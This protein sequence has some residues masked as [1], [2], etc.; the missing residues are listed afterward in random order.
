MG[1]VIL[2]QTFVQFKCYFL[3]VLMLAAQVIFPSTVVFADNVQAKNRPEGIPAG[4]GASVPWVEYEA[5]DGETNATIVGPSTK[6]GDLAGEASGRKAVKLSSTGDHVQ[7]ITTAPANSIVIRNCIPD[8]PKGG[9]IDA[10]ISL[11]VNGVFRKSITLSSKNSWLY[12]NEGDPTKNPAEGNPRRLYDEAQALVGEIPAGAKV[13]LQKDSGDTADY[14]GIDFIDLEQV[15]PPLPRPARYISITDAALGGIKSGDDCSSALAQAIELCQQGKYAGVYIPQGTFIQT[16]QAVI[17]GVTVRGA[18][19]WYSK[20]YNPYA[21]DGDLGDLGFIIDG[22]NCKFYDFALFGNNNRRENGG[23]AFCNTTFAKMEV[24]NVWIEHTLCGL[25]VGGKG[26]SI[27]LHVYNTRIRNTFADGINLC[28][29]TQSSLIENCTARNTGDDAFAMWSAKDMASG[30]VQNNIIRNCTVQLPW[31]AAAFAIYGG[32][33][34]IIQDCVALD[35]LTYPGVTLS[36]EFDPVPFSGTTKIQRVSL[37]RCGGAFWNDAGLGEPQQFGAIW[38]YACKPQYSGIV[39]KDVDIISPTYAGIVFQ[40]KDGTIVNPSI[41]NV[42]IKDAGTFGICVLPY[43]P[44]SEI[45]ATRGAATLTN[46]KIT[47]TKATK[48]FVMNGSPSTFQI[49]DGGG[50]QLQ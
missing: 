46:V 16:E 34:N 8:A 17:K 15:A 45:G 35:T 19:M 49:I 20:L 50:N 11:Y 10:T 13:K 21:I 25:W 24:G 30:P 29:A 36:T 6:V 5:E 1:G 3:A 18:G 33:N 12:G 7:W 48:T 43:A 42:K 39:V 32:A 41:S 4:R 28:N 23:K 2:K 22:P 38:F 31:R 27:G 14:Y 47:N 9:G 44:N 40:S 37:V 26:P